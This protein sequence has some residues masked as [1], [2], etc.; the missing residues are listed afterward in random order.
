M[1]KISGPYIIDTTLRDGEQTPGV[2]FSMDEKMA[3]ARM[4]DQLGIDE[5]EAG[6]PAI[7]TDEQ[8]A[9]KSI[10][11]AGFSFVTSCWCRAK[12][13]DILQAAGLGT[14]SV[15]ISLPASDIQINT[16]GK[17]R[18]EILEDTRHAVKVA[19]DHF[20]HI[21][22]G[23]Q[24]SSRADQEFL[25]E[26]IHC[27]LEAGAHRIR[28]SDTVGI[29]DPFETF[30]LISE[31]KQRFPGVI[32]EFHGHNDLGHGT[33]NAMAAI[34]G[35]ADCVSATVNGLGERAGNSVLEEILANLLMKQGNTRF[36]TAVIHSLSTL[37]ASASCIDI[38]V[39]KPICGENAFRHESGIHTS[40]ILKNP[41]SYQILEPSDF[42]AAPISFSQGK[43]SGRAY[44]KHLIAT[45]NTR[46]HVPV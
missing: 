23:A 40:A 24:D 6:T 18:T 41:L 16:L 15:N 38:P 4:L 3:I 35:G 46:E 21:T 29:L 32:F 22:M 14:Q 42:G 43:H 7:G 44:L 27:A 30:T 19:R 13:S 8:E 20:P 31:L 45:S 25:N 37:V 1:M 17:T 11:G 36:H 10:A 9:I 26:F 39:H 12:A 28:V 33:S 5:V 2:A 34:R